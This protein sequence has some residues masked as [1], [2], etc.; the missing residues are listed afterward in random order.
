[1][2]FVGL[3]LFSAGLSAQTDS[4]QEYT[5]KYHFPQGSPVSEI[6]V[7]M[8]KGLLQASSALGSSELRKTENKDVFELVAY[9]GIAAFS[10]NEDGK[11]KSLRI[12]VQDV[13]ME[14][15]R[16]TEPADTIHR[17]KVSRGY[18]R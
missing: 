5:G 8:E 6:R 1:M 2:L 12:L 17:S 3:L 7:A 16:E 11:I 10:R 13:D 15:V 14:G 4:L 9:A 18:S